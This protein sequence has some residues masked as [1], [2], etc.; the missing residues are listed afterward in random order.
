MKDCGSCT[1]CCKLLGVA[2]IG[3]APGVTCQHCKPGLGCMIHS[4][5]FF[6]VDCAAFE[7]LWKQDPNGSFGD[8]DRPDRSKVVLS[9]TIDGGMVVAYVEPRNIE[10]AT[11]GRMGKRLRAVAAGGVNVVI[12]AGDQRKLLTRGAP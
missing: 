5:A 4:D 6:P 8:G 2:E 12:L 1:L 10:R 11:H 9:A 3:K 7:C